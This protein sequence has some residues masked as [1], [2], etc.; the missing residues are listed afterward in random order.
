MQNVSKSKLIAARQCPRRLWLEVNR[1][2]LRETRTDIEARFATGHKVG[3]IARHRYDPTARG[4]LIDIDS[5][6]F[7]GVFKATQTALGRKVPIFE[8]AFQIPGALALADI[9]LPAPRGRFKLIEVKSSTSV[10]DVYR[11]DLAIQLHVLEHTGLKLAGV[12][13]AHIDSSWTYPGEGDYRGLLVEEDVEADVRERAREVAHWI[14]DAQYILALPEM[15]DAETGTPCRSPYECPFLDFC[16]AREP[17]PDYPLTGLPRAK[18]A[19]YD[20]GFRDLREPPDAELNELQHRVKRCTLDN[21]RYFDTRGAASALK[22]YTLPVSFFDFETI[23]F[24]VPVWKDTRPYQQIPFQYSAHRL[25]ANGTLHHSGCLDLNGDD[26]ART[27]AEH[28][29]EDLG[30]T[31]AVFVYFA[32]FEKS[33]LKELAE[34]F[35]D[36][37]PALLAVRERIVDLLPVAREYYYH[38]DQQ[39]SWSIKA[40]LPTLAP[41]LDYSDLDGVHDGGDAQAA[42]LEAIDTATTIL[43]RAEIDRQLDAYCERDTYALVVLWKT[44]MGKKD[45]VRSDT[46]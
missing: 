6:G 19:W 42:Y 1:N 32:A 9:L 28:L 17:Q 44:F 26:P 11:D 37:A 41:E 5:L 10:K 29:I 2:D 45:A 35:S 23:Q 46:Q 16:Q 14:D 40:V 38:P 33:R 39:G 13:L 27:I 8:A 22:T 18:K 34:R 21:T 24:A 36:L 25:D 15:P 31:G 12:A 43:R 7:P 3:A 20:A 30:D 4:T